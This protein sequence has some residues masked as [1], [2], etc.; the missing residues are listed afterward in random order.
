MR[1]GYRR[2]GN[3]KATHALVV[4]I[5]ELGNTRIEANAK[6]EGTDEDSGHEDTCEVPVSGQALVLHLDSLRTVALENGVV[7]GVGEL[8]IRL[9]Q[10]LVLVREIDTYSH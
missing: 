10:C 3:G 5:E 1:S 8:H 6:G 2:R 7:E 4:G 9:D